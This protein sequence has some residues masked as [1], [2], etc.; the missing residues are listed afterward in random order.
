MNWL[1]RIIRNWLGIN[2]DSSYPHRFVT[3]M[4]YRDDLV[5][6]DGNDDIYRF[7]MNYDG[8]PEFVELVMRNPLEGGR[9]NDD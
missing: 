9:R 6:V 1:K 5:C 7:R 3:L 4:Y 8:N 2:R